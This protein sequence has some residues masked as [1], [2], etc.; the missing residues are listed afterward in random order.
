ME[1]KQI[2]A[3][4]KAGIAHR[5]HSIRRRSCPASSPIERG[6]AGGRAA[7]IGRGGE[8]EDGGG[9]LRNRL[10]E[11]KGEVCGG[12]T[13]TRFSRV[14]LWKM[15]CFGDG[16]G[17]SDRESGD[18]TVGRCDKLGNCKVCKVAYEDFSQD[19]QMICYLA[20]YEF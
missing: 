9:D 12:S 17:P 5:R 7:T 8:G 14:L 15:E 4:R 20:N 6:A 11:G 18:R 10:R 16:Y 19:S 2:G 13:R 3:G 1:K